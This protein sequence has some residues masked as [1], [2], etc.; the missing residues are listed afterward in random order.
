MPAAI[1][2]GQL[3]RV[4]PRAC[5]LEADRVGLR[6]RRSAGDCFDT[7]APLRPAPS[8]RLR[9]V[10]SDHAAGGA[11]TIGSVTERSR[12][13]GVPGFSCWAIAEVSVQRWRT[14]TDSGFCT[15]ACQR[16]GTAGSG[17]SPP[18]VAISRSSPSRRCRS[19]YQLG[20][21]SRSPGAVGVL[22][23]WTTSA[24]LDNK[25]S[26]AAHVASG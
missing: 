20:T 6:G 19:C 3:A 9:A 18:T 26:P 4:L 12:R 23:G 7:S 1:Q 24:A 22:A 5:R 8:A 16:T 10:G 17:A 15:G 14:T 11:G 25:R 2:R 21:L 13:D